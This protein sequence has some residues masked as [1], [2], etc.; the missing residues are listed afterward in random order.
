MSGDVGQAAGAIANGATPPQADGF[1]AL[2][3]HSIK[4]YVSAQ[5]D[6]AARLGGAD[7][8]GQWTVRMSFLVVS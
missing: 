1:Q 7:T 5:P 6:L 8:I 4:G 3:E 2:D